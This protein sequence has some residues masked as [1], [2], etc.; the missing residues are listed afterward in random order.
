MIAFLTGATG[1]VGSHVAETLVARGY[2][3][4][5]LAR[6]TSDTKWLNHLIK[7]GSVQLVEGSLAHEQSLLSAVKDVDMV[8]H[9]AGVTAARS[10]DDFF[11]GNQIGTRNLLSATLHANPSVKRFLHVSSQTAVGPAHS[12]ATP[13]TSD[14]PCRPIT[15]YGESKKAAEDEVLALQHQLPVTIVRPPAVYGQRDTAVFDYFKAVNNGLAPLI[16][17]D[18][19]YVSLV[20]A[21]DL[22]RGIVEAA[23]SEHT[24]SKSYFVSSDEFYT[25]PQ[26]TAITKRILDKKLVLQLRLPHGLVMG[27]AGISGFFGRFS[28]KPPV[29]DFEKGRDI[30]Q[31]YWICSTQEARRDFGYTQKVSLEDGIEK[32][33]RWYR[34]QGW[35]SA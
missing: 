14:T 28:T 7:A 1:F 25:W 27:I 35:L 6:K 8:I 15:T 33:I 16:G 3:V 32:T 17:F 26:I 23:E 2:N 30:I 12:L 10:R 18:T 20:H 34:E 5:C 4:R 24:I 29:L 11:Q 22:A 31:S 9:V 21:E 19:K 13:A